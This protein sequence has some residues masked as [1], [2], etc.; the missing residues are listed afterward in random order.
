MSAFCSYDWISVLVIILRFLKSQ[1]RAKHYEII[2]P[3]KFIMLSAVANHT[4]D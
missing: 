3:E 1:M 2:F 4:W